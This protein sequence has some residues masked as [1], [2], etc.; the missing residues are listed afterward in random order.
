MK[1]P[2]VTNRALGATDLVDRKQE[3]Q[4]V[5]DTLQQG[6][7]LF[8]IGPRRYGKTSILRAACEELAQEDVRTLMLNVESYTSV[9][10]LIRGIVAGAASLES[11][12]SAGVKTVKDFFGVFN[13]SLTVNAEGSVTAS[14]GLK[15]PEKKEQQS[16]LFIEALDRLELLA[17]KSGKQTG[18][19]L[20]EFQHLLKLG[21]NAVE[22]QL[23]AAVQMHQ[24]LGYVF[25]GSQ[26]ALI[27]DMVTNHARPFYRLG[28]HLVVGA[29]ERTEFAEFLHQG[30]DALKVKPQAA[31]LER[32]FS[33]AEEVPYNV[34]ALARACWQ[35]MADRKTHTLTAVI[36]DQV[37]ASMLVGM[38]PIY[39]PQWNNL[40]LLQQRA[41]LGVA[42]YGGQ[43]LTGKAVLKALELSPGTMQ[44]SLA[45]LEQQSIL[46]REQRR[47]GSIW[48][49]EDPLFKGW[50]LASVN[51]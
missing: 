9:E 22:G 21:G 17:K 2:F 38:E 1:N 32:I 24:H 23:R 35:E 20:D 25:A 40:T 51:T 11:N 36:V 39:A 30:F 10:E 16:P 37:Y 18:L 7:K 47:D 42:R 26:T 49:F 12:L 5:K 48:R 19:I 15:T 27:A 45:S 34:Q 50:L 13:P 41:L 4:R 8:M 43:G 31:A 6:G 33:L 46:R 29:I 3:L 14:L 44:T 28:E